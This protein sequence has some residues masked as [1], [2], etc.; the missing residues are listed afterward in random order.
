MSDSCYPMDYR[1][2]GSS[3]HGILQVRTL[4]WVAIS[5]SS[6]SSCLRACV[7]CVFQSLTLEKAVVQAEMAQP[8]GRQRA[9]EDTCVSRALGKSAR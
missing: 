3:A 2:L 7:A 1:P 8:S 5:F 9:E 6:G 4:E